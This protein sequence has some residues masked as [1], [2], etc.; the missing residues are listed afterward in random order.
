MDIRAAEITRII[1]EQLG[2]FSAGVDVSEVGTVLAVGD[3]AHR[4]SPPDIEVAVKVAD[5]INP[6][7]IQ[8]VLVG[9]G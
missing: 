3:A 5:A 4:P 8:S 1:K 9:F 7:W 6:L 2:G